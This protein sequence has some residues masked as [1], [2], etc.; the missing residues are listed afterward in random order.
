VPDAE[1]LARSRHERLSDHVLLVLFDGTIGSFDI[2]IHPEGLHFGFNKD[3]QNPTDPEGYSKQ[4]RTDDGVEQLDETARRKIVRMANSR[5]RINIA[6]M[7]KELGAR[8]SADFALQM[9]EGVERLRF[10]VSNI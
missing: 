10:D 4:L 7:A 9:I 5:R 1:K 6:K 3:P 2:G 8:T